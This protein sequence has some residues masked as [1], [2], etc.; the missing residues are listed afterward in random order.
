MKALRKQSLDSWTLTNFIDWKGYKFSKELDE[1]YAAQRREIKSFFCQKISVSLKSSLIY[2][3][4]LVLCE[5]IFVQISGDDML[6]EK[7]DIKPHNL[8]TDI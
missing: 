3:L 8:D 5:L 7:F 2:W 6:H 4:T 1:L